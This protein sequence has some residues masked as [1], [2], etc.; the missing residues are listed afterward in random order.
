MGEQ[1]N[2]EAVQE[3]YAAFGRGDVKPILEACADDVAWEQWDDNSAQRAGVSWLAPRRGPDGAAEFFGIV[4]Q[5]Q[6]HDFQV[7]G[8]LAGGGQ[9]GAEIEIEATVP[10]T[11]ERFRDQELHLWTF[12]DDGKVTRFRHYVDTAKH[13]AVAG[14]GQPA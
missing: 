9:V 13:A 7:K 2:L 10:E 3:M 12:G 11:G 5:W 8:L 6:I 1:Q 4:G 14:V